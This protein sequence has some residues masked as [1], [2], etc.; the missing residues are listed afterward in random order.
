MILNN[1]RQKNGVGLCEIEI[2]NVYIKMSMRIF[3]EK[4]MIKHNA[5]VVHYV[6]IL[7]YA[8]TNNKHT[9]QS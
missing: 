1:S 3:R 7:N 4:K 6:A 5:Y 8:W 9:N 2:F